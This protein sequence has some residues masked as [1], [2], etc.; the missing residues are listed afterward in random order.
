MRI[1]N[2][3]VFRWIDRFV[4][5]AVACRNCPKWNA[6]RTGTHGF[7]ELSPPFPALT[8]GARAITPALPLRAPTDWC[9]QHPL[10]FARQSEGLYYMP[11]VAGADDNAGF[12]RAPRLDEALNFAPP[13]PENI[14]AAR[15]MRD[16]LNGALLNK[17]LNRDPNSA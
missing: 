11:G 8:P 3:Y 16:G 5:G 7:C 1:S 2:P 6:N 15:A 9:A 4:T 12:N 17:P 10:H 14:E 13:A